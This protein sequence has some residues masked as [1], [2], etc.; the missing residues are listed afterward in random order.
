MITEALKLQVHDYTI[1]LWRFFLLRV[2]L[3]AET[4]PI[5]FAQ[6]EYIIQLVVVLIVGY[7]IWKADCCLLTK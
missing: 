7:V 2:L 5:D 6:H 3:L 4:K 1:K